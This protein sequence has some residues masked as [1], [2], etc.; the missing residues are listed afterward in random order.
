M[1]NSKKNTK[2]FLYILL[3]S[4]LITNLYYID[5]KLIKENADKQ[6]FFLMPFKL[7]SLQSTRFCFL[8]ETEEVI[9]TKIC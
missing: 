2:I 5:S 3:H 7:H 4:Y 6:H 8:F 1:Q 9:Q